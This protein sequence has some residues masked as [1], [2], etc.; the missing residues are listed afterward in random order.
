MT[1]IGVVARD[2]LRPGQS[3]YTHP[4]IGLYSFTMLSRRRFLAL[5][6]LL[7]AGPSQAALPERQLR[8]GLT[9]VILDDRLSFL[10]KWQHWLQH[11]LDQPVRFV[12]RANYREIT[13]LLLGGG[14]ELAW[15]CGYPFVREQASLEL[16]AVPRHHGSST[17]RSYIIT[18]SENHSAKGLQELQGRVFAFSDPDS[19]SG[20]LY[21]AYRLHQMGT[22]PQHFFSR[23]FFT[24]GHRNTIEA[25]AAGLADGG[26]VD[27]YVWEQTALHRPQLVAR[28]R[29]I[30][31]S[32][33]F[34]FPP[35]VTRRDLAPATRERLQALLL[36]MSTDPLGRQLLASLGLDGFE[37]GDV[38]NYAGIRTMAQ[39]IDGSVAS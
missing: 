27:S 5:A 4:V 29:V 38:G 9:P 31:K 39:V 21:P 24:W 30:E 6:S 37:C 14:L 8:F 32:P 28:T 25:V 10:R 36:R 7:L 20:Y 11:G 2:E 23:S 22:D 34:G 1:R 17:Y 35:I 19:N 13:D 26:A 18:A 33:A 12:Q 3:R 16:L 15:I